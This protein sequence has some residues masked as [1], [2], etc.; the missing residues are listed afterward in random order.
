MSTRLYEFL[1]GV[2]TSNIPT[3]ENPTTDQ[4]NISK[5]YADVTYTPKQAVGGNVDDIPALK[6]LITQTGAPADRVDNQQIIVSDLDLTYKYSSTSTAVS[7]DDTVVR[8]SDVANDGLAGRWLKSLGAGGG[9]SSSGASGL[10]A[11]LQKAEMEKSGIFTEPLDNSICI[12]GMVQP[13][14][15]TVVGRLIKDHAASATALEIAWAPK[16]LDDADKDITSTAN[17][18]ATGAGTSL[19]LGGAYKLS[20]ADSIQFDKT[21]GNVEAGARYARA[22]QDFSLAEH[23]L[24]FYIELPSITNLVGVYVKI[25]AD[26]TSNYRKFSLSTQADGSALQV[27]SNLMRLD[28]SSAGTDTGTG[29]DTSKLS[30]YPA[31]MGVETSSAGQTY[32]GIRLG[33]I[34]FPLKNPKKLGLNGS[35]VTLYDSSNKQAVIL[36]IGSS[37]YDVRIPLKSGQSLSASYI[38]GAAN[39]ASASVE[40]STLETGNGI[41]AKNT[42][43]TSGAIALTQEVRTS[44]IL[45]ESLAMGLKV[46]VDSSSPQYAA[47]VTAVGGSTVDITQ[48]TD[49]SANWASGDVVRVHRPVYSASGDVHYEWVS[50]KTLTASSTHS[51]ST[52][53][54]TLP[55]SG[56]A[57]GDVISKKHVT[58][59]Q[60]LVALGANENYSALS[61]DTAPNGIQILDNSFTIPN[62]ANLWGYY[63][64]GGFTQ[65]DAFKNRFGYSG[66]DLSNFTSGTGLT[67]QGRQLNGYPSMGV[68]GTGFAGLAPTATNQIDG[69]GEQV[70]YSLWFYFDGVSASQRWVMANFYIPSGGYGWNSYISPSQSVLKWGLYNGGLN[71]LATSPTMSVGWHHLFFSIVNGVSQKV[72]L[73]GVLFGSASTTVGT[74]GTSQYFGVG[75]DPYTPAEPAIGMNFIDLAIWVGGS[76]LPDSTI[77]KIY[78]QGNYRPFNTGSMREVYTQNGLSGQ[79]LSTKHV[80][81]TT[82]TAVEPVISKIGAIK[83]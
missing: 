4:D 42:A 73:D 1:T 7:D 25:Y 45:R 55:V 32:S 67:V 79:K 50:E 83:S 48:E 65:A 18:T 59:Y 2:T 23:D 28:T 34:Q 54:L 6:A 77:S 5:G 53:V 81:S 12:S 78:N 43:L 52:T 40:R 37:L 76:L 82:S 62:K 63:S 80:I 14:T 24:T 10:E 3:A 20:T 66:L 33:S 15:E 36:D 35:E 29:W 70:Q 56:I 16:Y 61:V 46:A 27:G 71:Y 47:E 69:N 72:Y 19:A 9:G 22:S 26:T 41:I 11:V 68:T 17:F 51:G 13:F 74:S 39:S 44:R 75:S 64:L 8:P 31:E 38:G 49:L 57:V 58:S 21:T 30:K 60:S